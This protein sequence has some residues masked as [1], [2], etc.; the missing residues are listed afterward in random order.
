VQTSD[1]SVSSA[2]ADLPSYN[3]NLKQPSSHDNLSLEI[4]NSSYP[5]GESENVSD[6]AT[7]LKN[8]INTLQTNYANAAAAYTE[9]KKNY[10]KVNGQLEQLGQ[11]SAQQLADYLPAPFDLHIAKSNKAEFAKFEAFYRAKDNSEQANEYERLIL[12]FF[13]TSNNDYLGILKKV[14]CKMLQC[15]LYLKYENYEAFGASLSAMKNQGWANELRQGAS[16]SYVREYNGISHI[17]FII[18]YYF[19]STGG[20]SND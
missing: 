20:N 18:H 6:E 17:E 16:S 5:I 12:A 11:V 4:A 8:K 1:A 14:D 19:S 13:E 10:K 15:T 7:Q 2:A 3:D 9:L